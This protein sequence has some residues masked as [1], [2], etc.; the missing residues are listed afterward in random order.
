MKHEYSMPVR[1]FQAKKVALPR[2]IM[3]FVPFQQV[4]ML[5]ESLLDTS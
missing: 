4:L 3:D 1:D 5:A 2:R